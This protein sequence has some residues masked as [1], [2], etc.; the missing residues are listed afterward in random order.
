MV[1]TYVIY[2]RNIYVCACIYY[3]SMANKVEARLRAIGD[4]SNNT[5]TGLKY[6]LKKRKKK[7]TLRLFELNFHLRL[8]ILLLFFFLF[9][10]FVPSQSR[11]LC[12]RVCVCFF[13]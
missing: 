9:S 2:T 4:P 5:S 13:F 7:P 11:S 8:C 12:V 3:N 6:N 10:N 1:K